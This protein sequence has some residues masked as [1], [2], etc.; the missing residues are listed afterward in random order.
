[1]RRSDCT[2]AKTRLADGL[3][4]GQLALKGEFDAPPPI[5]A[6]YEDRALEG[7]EIR[8]GERPGHFSLRL[9]LPRAM[10]SDG[11]HVVMF[12][13][14]EADEVLASETIVAGDTLAED[15]RDELALL[16]A[17]LDMLKRAFRRHC[18]ETS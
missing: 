4:E 17:E 13:D 11:V 16:R 2:L 5:Q 6:R 15:I 7:L 18:L 3:W 9:P 1:M 14:A 8:P 10:L 12:V